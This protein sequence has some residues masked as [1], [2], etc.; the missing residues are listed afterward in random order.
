MA[1]SWL[2]T[3]LNDRLSVS[4]SENKSL[5]CISKR[6]DGRRNCCWLRKLC[7]FCGA[8]PCLFASDCA[9]TSDVVLYTAAGEVDDDLA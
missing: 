8:S 5:R 1:P 9:S 6:G 3:R 4:F 2:L 7:A